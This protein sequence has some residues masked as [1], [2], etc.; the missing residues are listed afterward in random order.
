MPKAKEIKILLVDDQESMRA[1]GR[2]ALQQLGFGEIELARSG[3]E[4]LDVLSRKKIDLVISDW[5]M[6]DVDGLKLLKLVRKHP[7]TK[8]LPFIMA[9]GQSERDQVRT[10]A[11][12]GVN[13]Y[14]VKPFDVQTLQMKI[15]AVIGKLE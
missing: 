6:D 13:N 14:I 2:Y 12:A 1:L 11:Q 15:E 10:A 8:K 7:M 3:R 9:T 4:A 5:N